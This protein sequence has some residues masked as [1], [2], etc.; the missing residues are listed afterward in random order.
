MKLKDI[1]ENIENPLDDNTIRYLYDNYGYMNTYDLVIGRSTKPNT[2]YDKRQKDDYNKLL[3]EKWKESILN[4]TEER[5][6]ELKN[7]YNYKDIDRITSILSS[8]LLNN[9]RLDTSE[10]I[11]RFLV[12]EKL[13]MAY[14]CLPENIL[15]DKFKHTVSEKIDISKDEYYATHH[16]NHRLY[17]NIDND[18]LYKFTKELVEKL[19]EKNLPFYFKMEDTSNRKDGFVL[20]SDTRNLTKYMECLDEVFEKNKDLRDS[21]HSPLMFAGKIS[22]YYSIGDEPIQNTNLYSFNTLRSSCVDNAMNNTIRRWMYENQNIKLKRKGQVIGFKDY[23]TDKVIDMLIDDIYNNNRKYKNY[24]NLDEDV[25]LAKN[26]PNFKES[27]RLSVDDYVNGKNSD[28][29][30]VYEKK[31]LNPKKYESPRFLGAISPLIIDVLIKKELGNKI[32]HNF[33]DCSGYFKYYLQEQLKANNVDIEKPCFNID[34]KEK[35][36]NTIYRIGR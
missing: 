34:T 28:L 26:L 3:F 25:F 9:Y 27:L 4:L 2:L 22:P 33:A 5:R 36:E 13:D 11:Y 35:F 29:V 20:Y 10:G 21:I 1:Y 16:V 30:K 19:D 12:S 32:I 14:F 7:R 6:R 18:N 8:P 24:Y 15:D 23:L 17:V 31:E